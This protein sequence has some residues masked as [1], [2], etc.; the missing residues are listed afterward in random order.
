M[1]QL[2]DQKRAFAIFAFI[3]SSREDATKAETAVARR[4]A[5][6]MTLAVA[7]GIDDRLNH[8]G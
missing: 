6:E 4:G 7:G 1:I 2:R 3:N 5:S 8:E